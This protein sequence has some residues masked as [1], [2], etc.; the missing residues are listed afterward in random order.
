MTFTEQ[1]Q[2]Y[3]YQKAQDGFGEYIPA[4]PTLQTTAPTWANV[5]NTSGDDILFNGRLATNGKYRL[6]VNY[7]AD[8]AWQRDMFVVTRFGIL[9]VTG[10]NEETRKR[11]MSI[12]AEY[13]EGTTETGYLNTIYYTVPA[14]AATVTIPAVNGKMIYLIFR[15]G[16][17]KKYVTASPQVN[18]IM[19]AGSVLSL[20]SGDIFGAGERITILSL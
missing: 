18:E 7:R 11:T 5:V 9:D 20:V 19:V 16:I 2:V 10:F 3:K 17:E 1:I 6:D 12:L 14:D 15:D 13:V 4:P 8:F